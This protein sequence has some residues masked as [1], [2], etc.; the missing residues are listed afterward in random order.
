MVK[1]QIWNG[2]MIKQSK[3]FKDLRKLGAIIKQT[4]NGHHMIKHKTF[5]YTLSGGFEHSKQYH[6]WRVR[7]LYR[8]LKLK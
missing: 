6:E 7:E 5:T 2:I 4:R 3:L 1:K 8:A